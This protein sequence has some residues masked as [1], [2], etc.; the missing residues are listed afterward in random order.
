MTAATVHLMSRDTQWDAA[1]RLGLTVGDEILDGGSAARVFRATG[2]DG[3]DVALKVL[4]SD[5]G[6]VDGHDLDSFLGKLR[7]LSWIR[8]GDE[9][10]AARCLPVLHAVRGPGWAA[11]TT[12]FYES[13][14]SAASLRLGPD[15]GAFFDL[16]AGLVKDLIVYGYGQAV[17]PVG[18]DFLT[19]A[20]VD[21]IPRRW[22]VLRAALPAEVLDADPLVVNG[23]PCVN[24]KRML[25]GLTDLP[26]PWWTRLAPPR[27]MFPAHGDLNTR[28]VLVGADGFRLIDPR[29]ATAWWDPVYDL[30]K[31][32]FSLTVWDPALRLGAHVRRDGDGWLAGFRQPVYPGYAAAARLFIDRLRAMPAL[33]ALFGDDPHW[34]DRLLWA[35]ALHTLA[36]A[37]CR[38]SDRKPRHDPAGRPIAPEELA[39][40]HYLLGTLLLNDLAGSAG[41]VDAGSHL[42]LVAGTLP[43]P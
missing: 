1:R 12:P 19:S 20:M 2:T 14:D 3:A 5:A 17:A 13:V 31:T 39:L 23:V 24:P 36:E 11:Y 32:L 29:G 7:Q 38:L 43:T 27:L 21:R 16:Q 15:C 40:C 4:T 30:A 6:L 9:T 37:P 33:A 22:P 18:P 8:A 28:N 26:R 41:D 25:A 10:L 35:H 34:V 42:A